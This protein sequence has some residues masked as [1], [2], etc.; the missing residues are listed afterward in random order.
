MKIKIKKLS[1]EKVL[2]LPPQKHKKP[3]RQNFFFRLLLKVVSLPDLIATH[4]RVRKVGMERLGRR[5]PALFLMNHSSFIDLEIAS[6]V[7]FPRPFNIV[8]TW[9]GFVGKKLLM[10]LLGCIPTHKFVTDLNLVK[11]IFYAIRELKSSVLMFPEACYTFDGTAT[12]LPETLGHMVKKLGAPV[13]L[14][15][16][17]G[18]FTRDPLYNNL[19]RRRVKVSAEMRY[20]LSPEELAEMSVEEINALLAESFSFDSFR[21][22]QENRV[23]VDEKFRADSLNRVLYKCPACLAEG[24]MQG[25]GTTITCH[26]CGKAYEL[27]EYGYMKA[28]TGET[29]FPHLPDWTAWERECVRR[30]I[31]AGEYRMDLSVDLYLL[32][33]T[34]CLY[35]VGEGRLLHTAEGFSLTG[36][37]GRLEYSQRAIASYTLNSD[38]FWYEIG[39][40]ICIGN[41]AVQYYCFP[42]DAGDVVTKARFAT[43]ELYKLQKAA[44]PRR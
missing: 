9:D 17:Q 14:I 1:Y 5:E 15:S 30:E 20:L 3:L 36:C 31:E 39:D 28:L 32:V 23:C 22:Q 10:R 40:V 7:L 25:D 6:S 4:F 21:W 34:K 2:A 41:N 19:Q 29:E 12:P 11:D 18:A 13:V 24:R 27:D 16:T 38:Y 33:D 35:H 44:L 43:E 26:A 42:R 37:D 8:C